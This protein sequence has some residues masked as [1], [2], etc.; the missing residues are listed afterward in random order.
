[1]GMDLRITWYG[2]SIQTSSLCWS[3][4]KNFTLQEYDTR[5]QQELFCENVKCGILISTVEFGAD[6]GF[7]TCGDSQGRIRKLFEKSS[8][9]E[10]DLKRMA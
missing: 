2:L 3:A 7:G 5:I 9:A 4:K 6:G 10:D 8:E 1:M